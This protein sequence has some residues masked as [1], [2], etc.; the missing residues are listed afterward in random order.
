MGRIV[1]GFFLGLPLA[2]ILCGLCAWAWPGAWR[3]VLIPAY[4]AVFPVW[5]L[6]VVLA[7]YGRSWQSVLLGFTSLGVLGYGCI[8]LFRLAG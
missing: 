1:L 7:Q 5:A 2:V 8:W 4:I 6:L 3:T